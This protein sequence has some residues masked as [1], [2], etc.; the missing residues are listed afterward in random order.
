MDFIIT[1][2]VGAILTAIGSTAVAGSLVYS[3]V[4][5]LVALTFAVGLYFLSAFLTPTTKPE[6]VAVSFRK[7]VGPRYRHYGRVKISGQWVFC[8]PYN[9]GLYKVIALGQGPFYSFESFWID[10]N[11]VTLDSNG[12]ATTSVN[13]N[14]ATSRNYG[15]NVRILSRLGTTTQTYYSELGAVFPEWD[16]THVGKGVASL[17]AIQAP[18]KSKFFS[19]LFPNAWNTNYRV[20][21]KTSKV[22][23]PVT[24]VI[25]YDDNAAAC[26]RD[27]FYN[28]EGM[29]LPETILTTAKA[30]EGWETAYTKSAAA[31]SI[32]AGGTEKRYRIC[33]SY[34]LE[35]RPA[36]ILS[37]MLTACDGKFKIT[38]D[39]GI[40]L[41]VGDY[42]EPTVILT[43]ND[44]LS[45]TDFGH[46]KDILNTA[47]VIKATF[48]SPLQD[49]VTTDAD[50]W[51]DETDVEERGEISTSYEYIFAPSHS[52]CRRL[53]KIAAARANPEWVGTFEFNLK[54]LSAIGER[55]IRIQYAP[56][57]IDSVFEVSKLNINV[58]EGNIVKSVT[59]QVTSITSEAYTWNYLTEEG[60]EPAMD[61]LATDAVIPVASNF[62]AVIQRK[63]VSGSYFPYAFLSWGTPSW[64]SLV[65]RAEYKKHSDT[66]WIT[67]GK[68][69]TDLFVSSPLLD[70]GV[71]YDFRIAQSTLSGKLSNYSDII[72]LTSIANL[73]APSVI[74]GLSSTGGS[75]TATFSWTTPNSPN[76]VACNFYRN[77]T[78]SEGTAV[79]VHT[80]WGAPSTADTWTETGLTAGSYYFW[81]RSKNGSGVESTS[82]A[83]GMV[84]VT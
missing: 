81:A 69:I 23:N 3:A 9:G 57:D 67:I 5:A 50:E 22:K 70:D 72:T 61:D 7:A 65:I 29:R 27:Y 37:K 48:T 6:D 71:S 18:V 10:N 55:F 73:T 15:A 34:S 74:T 11:K 39:G 52:Q 79:F 36:D 31:Y 17:L 78:N 25:A 14:G 60:T 76:Y 68:N 75:G 53:M 63:Q 45:I 84:T 26:I 64:E 46:G 62:N 24:G 42:V 12:Y 2:I 13:L 58:G 33:G 59:I 43:E 21:A 80:E 28:D 1:P 82:V 54:G 35:E 38:S 83:S 32:K 51:R 77:T 30:Q 66:K 47:N 19:D 40:T 4:Y 20:I 8:A 41:D 56:L 44:I 49:F 16:S